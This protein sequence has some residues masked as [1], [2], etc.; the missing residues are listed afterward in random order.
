M[1]KPRILIISNNCLSL[2]DS[3]GRT[4][5]GF[6][7]GWPTDCLAQFYLQ[8]SQPDFSV[9]RRFFRVTDREAL[10]A[11]LKRGKCGAQIHENVARQ[12][13]EEPPQ[14]NAKS[15]VRTPVTMLLRELV[16]SSR[17]WMSE[18]F[19]RWVEEFSPELI[20]LQ[21]GDCAFMFRLA[22]DIAAQYHVPLVIYNSEG[23]YFK[24]FDYFKS[25]GFAHWCYPIFRRHFCR[26]FRKTVSMAACSFYICPALQRDY[27]REFNLPSE[28]IYTSTDLT[29]PVCGKKN[30]TNDSFTVSYLGNLGVGRHEPLIEI[31]RTLQKISPDLHL[32]IYGKMPDESVRRAFEECGGICCH[33]FVPYDQVVEIMQKSDLLIHTENFSEFYRE[34]LKYAFS[35][36]IADSLASGTCFLLYAPEEMACTQYLRDNGAGYVVSDTE[37]LHDTLR[38]LWEEPEQRKRYL[39]NAKRLVEENHRSAQVSKKFQDILIEVAEGYHENPSSK[40]RI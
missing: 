33:G 21:A 14:T 40:L 37:T 28:V 39:E 31:A 9:C 5:R 36:K 12:K 30:D 4:L 26:Q 38:L 11:F 8:N 23:Y 6:L 18:E 1:K 29:M 20:L 19:N 24:T 25:K 10:Q 32:N 15:V 27:D 2:T 16:W 35:T 34:D 13:N 3:N 7:T 22:E 17:A